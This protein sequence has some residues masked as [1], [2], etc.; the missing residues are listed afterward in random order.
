MQPN[1]SCYWYVTR[2]I[3]YP[4]ATW[5]VNGTQVGTNWDLTYSSSTR[6]LLEVVVT[7]GSNFAMASKFVTVNGDAGT[8]Y[9]E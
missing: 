3:Q 1:A 7:D 6:F 2:G 8:C 4:S 9:V 5:S